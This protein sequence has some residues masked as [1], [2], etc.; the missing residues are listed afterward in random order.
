MTAVSVRALLRVRRPAL[1]IRRNA[2]INHGLERHESRPAAVL[3]SHNCKGE[4]LF[5]YLI[6]L[7]ACCLVM[8]FCLRAHPAE[9][10]VFAASSLNDSLKEIAADYKKSTGDK[11]VF[12]F[13]ASS[14]LARQI[15]EGAPADIFFSADDAKMD[16]LGSKGLIIDKTRSS[17]LSNLLVIVVPKDAERNLRSAYDLTNAIVHR[18]ALGD[19]KTVPI[20]I[21]AKDYLQKLG[22]WGAVETK[23]V[24][25]ENVR[26]ASAAVEAGNA[27]AA[28]VYRTEAKIGKGVR[29]AVE[30]PRNEGPK[31]RY[32]VALLKNAPHEQAARNFLREL[33]GQGAAKIFNK[34]GF[35]VQGESPK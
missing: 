29:I 17:P 20:G 26:A 19:P 9:I 7:V 2:R 5:S 8:S 25:T 22:V 4:R 33:K 23:L 16:T 32:S 1:Q 11:V 34:F 3:T 31:I 6:R 27:D 24:I 30:I 18:I 21:Y 28:F 15:E 10:T 13:A 35:I 14:L 12:N